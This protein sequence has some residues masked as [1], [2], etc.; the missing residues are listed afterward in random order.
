M[1]FS[2]I[3]GYTPIQNALFMTRSDIFKLPDILYSISLK[4]GCF[5]MFPAKTRRVII[6]LFSRNLVISSRLKPQSSASFTGK[7]NQHGSDLASDSTN[8]KLSNSE[9]LD[10]IEL[11]FLFLD[12]INVSIPCI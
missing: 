6:P 12:S 1:S 7:P 5:V 10:L 4:Y 11:K 9:S 3:P 2:V 8:D